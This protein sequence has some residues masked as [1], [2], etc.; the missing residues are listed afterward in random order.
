MKKAKKNEL[1]KDTV[2]SDTFHVGIELETYIPCE[3]YSRE[4]DHEACEQSYRENLEAEGDISLL[5]NYMGLSRDDARSVAPYFNSEEYIN[6]MMQDWSCGDDDCPHFTSDTDG[7][8]ERESL[9][10]DLIELTG[11]NSFKVV[12]DGSI[13]NEDQYTDA[14]ICWN[15]FASRETINDNAKI[16]THLIKSG[17]KFNKSCGLHINL[18]NYLNLEVGAVIPTARLDF[19]FNFVAESRKTNSF[20]NRNA[21]SGSEKYSMLYE[22]GDRVEFRFFSPTFDAEKLNHYVILAHVVYKRLA[23]VNA[24]LPKKTMTYFLD[25]MI[26]VNKISR[27]VAEHSLKQVNSLESYKQLIGEETSS[28]PT[29]KQTNLELIA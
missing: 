15:Y 1:K 17:A 22:Q 14:E 16:M 21:L 20:C 7:D 23:G 2:K 6:D 4:H 5:Q 24:K 11:N 3:D 9:E 29:K 26:N 8:S 13:R 10:T 27:E 28:R 19:L 18:N 25:K 12:E